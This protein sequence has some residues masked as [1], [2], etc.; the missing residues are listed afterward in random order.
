[1]TQLQSF[2]D[3]S[4]GRL[5]IAA[6]RRYAMTFGMAILP[7]S[8][9]RVLL[10][11]FCG[12]Q[13]GNGCYIGFNVICDTNYAELIKIGDNVTISHDTVIYVHTASPVDSPLSKLYNHIRPVTIEN[14]AWIGARCIVLPGVTIA[15]D[16]MVGAGSVVASSTLPSSLFAGNPCKMIKVLSL[17]LRQNS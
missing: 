1:M 3:S 13:V 7:L 2:R 5:V 14:G 17:G 4:A 16:C 10:L 12:V 8:I 6:F 15:Q 9:L 11:R